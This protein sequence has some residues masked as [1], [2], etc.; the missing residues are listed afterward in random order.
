MKITQDVR[1]YAEAK[2]IE[3]DDAIPIGLAE[4]AEE[5]RKAGGTV[6]VRER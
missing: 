1:A 2:G 4:K 3:S 5:F 6:Y